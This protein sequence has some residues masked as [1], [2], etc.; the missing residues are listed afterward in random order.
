MIRPTVITSRLAKFRA[1]E[2]AICAC[3]EPR[4]VAPRDPS[5]S[6]RKTARRYERLAHRSV[7]AGTTV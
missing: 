1:I 6:A 7:A 4:R 2:L 5:S 3:D